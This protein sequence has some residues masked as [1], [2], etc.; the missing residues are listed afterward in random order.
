MS[1]SQISK[2]VRT[3]E[4]SPLFAVEGFLWAL[5]TAQEDG[6]ITIKRNLSIVLRSDLIILNGHQIWKMIRQ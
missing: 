5:S 3:K 4:S 2:K 6:N 1:G